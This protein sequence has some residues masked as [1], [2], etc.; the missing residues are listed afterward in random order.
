MLTIQSH[1]CEKAEIDQP[2]VWPALMLPIHSHLCEKAENDQLTQG[3]RLCYQSTHTCAKK[4]EMTSSHRAG[5]YVTNPLTLVR[6]WSEGPGCCCV[7]VAYV[8]NPLTL[9]RKSRK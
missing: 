6:K 5:A 7:T 2:A 8:T 1:L 4:Q 9:V 3:R